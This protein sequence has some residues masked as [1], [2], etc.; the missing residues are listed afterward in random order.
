[1]TL[2][3]IVAIVLL[4]QSQPAPEAQKPPVFRSGVE[5][6]AVDVSV[7]DRDG[8]PVTGLTADS[9]VVEI[10]GKR[11]TVARAEFID[12]TVSTSAAPELTD[13]SSNQAETAVTDARTILLVVD[14][15][16]FSASEGKAVF[17]RLAERV[18]RLFPRDPLGFAPL[19]GLGRPVEFT[20]DRKP[21]MEA[22][23]LLAG[24]RS[25]M[26]GGL[27]T[28]NLAL[29]EAMDIERGDAGAFEAAI[30]REC[31]GMGAIEREACR[32]DVESQ[33][34][35]MAG[36][37]E[38]EAERTLISLSRILEGMAA[39]PG[40]KYVIFVS[41]GVPVGQRSELATNLARSAAAS[42]VILHAFYVPRN[43][44][45]VSRQRISP[46]A[47]E[48]AR[49]EA[50]G[51]ELAVGSAGGALHRIIGDPGGAVERVRRE[52]AGV[53]R[54]GVEL[55]AIDADG[56]ARSIDVRVNRS[57]VTVR[58]HR[59][60]IP[61]ASSGRLGPSERLKRA[62]SSPLLER[63]IPVRLGTYSYLDE[64][65]RGSV[66]VSAEADTVP[67][68][69]RVAYAI[70]DRRGM[71]EQGGE[72]GPDAVYAEK[73]AP[74]LIMFRAAVAQGEHTVKLALVDAEGRT[75]SA[76]RPLVVNAGVP[77][78]FALGDLVILPAGVTS[79]R[80]RP[81]ARIA[82]G[83][84]QAQVYFEAYAGTAPA[85][86]TPIVLEIADSPEGPALVSARSAIA[87]KTQGAL[88]RAAGQMRFSPAALP[89]GRY[90]A[91]LS[92]E[93]TEVRAAR[94]F[95]VVAGSS[96]ALLSDESR[97]LV[98]LF[99]VGQ[100]LSGP[101]LAAV[102][103]RIERDAAENTG[104]KEVA[105]ALG[106]GSWR[107]LAPSTGNAVADATLRGLQA[108]AA[109]QAADA[110]R[111]FREALDQ[112]PEF[113]LALA[114][115]GGAWASVGRDRE[116]SRSW[117]TSLATG[118]DA[119]YLHGL[120]AD[121]LLRSGD[122]K[123]TREFLAEL[124]ESGGDVTPLARAR[125]FA[126]A[127]SGNRREAVAALDGW[128]QA[129]PEDQ[130]AL[131]LLVLALYELKTIDKD[132]AAAATFEVRAKEYVDRGGPR[133]ALVARWLK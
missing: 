35:L 11:R 76:M 63:D 114:L 96:A 14:D 100:F 5:L 24:S 128:L 112:D 7:I 107:D 64:R 1:M 10:G 89:P 66:I 3:T 52:M 101:L 18:E 99:S 21:V 58:A 27:G 31:S 113:T 133:R 131:F 84:R 59:Q 51:L 78:T 102:S 129:H 126:A 87:M 94:G 9:F 23:R 73:D 43:E 93:G 61:P 47:W 98:P 50:D 56:R 92:V 28:V 62:L 106:D 111:S 49:V 75:A 110:E 53:Y 22:L 20:T 55:D 2:A 74:P 104:A 115:A 97:A 132:A 127:I 72:L 25:P 17:L 60:I 90:F 39:L 69:L 12:F 83:S 40:T 124:Q 32:N 6:L 121:A 16:A 80:P 37:A 15:A 34:R 77:K 88:A 19:S 71:P 26:V 116:A 125:A 13:F 45:D 105:R 130:E 118:I 54:L 123:G 79:V 117:R 33:A 46:R 65:G 85:G 4:T 103:E 42:G 122:V 95:T 30:S 120:V 119:P 81:A 91:R 41:P 68:G 48:D 8:R 38:R 70:L 109:G 57:G 82:Q 86:K 29:A 36:E 67:K 44:M 108:L